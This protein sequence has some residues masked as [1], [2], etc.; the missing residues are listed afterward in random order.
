LL[1]TLPN[2]GYGTYEQQAGG[3]LGE[4]VADTDLDGMVS[5]GRHGKPLL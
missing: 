2:F 4:S 1:V 5:T 3:A